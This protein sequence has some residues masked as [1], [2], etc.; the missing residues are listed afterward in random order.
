[1]DDIFKCDLEQRTPSLSYILI[2]FQRASNYA[3]IMQRVVRRSN[4][5]KNTEHKQKINNITWTK[6]PSP[7]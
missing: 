5:P 2:H 7:L 1:M 4:A 3:R 6:Q